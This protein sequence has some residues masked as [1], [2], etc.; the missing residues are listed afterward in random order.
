MICTAEAMATSRSAEVPPVNTVIR[1]VASICCEA[2][3]GPGTRNAGDRGQT[4]GRE[5]GKESDAQR[6]HGTESRI[7][8]PA[9]RLLPTV[10]PPSPALRMPGPTVASTSPPDQLLQHVV[11]AHDAHQLAIPPHQ[12]GGALSREHGSDPIHRGPGVDFGK[13]RFHDLA[14]RTLQ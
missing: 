5:S 1:M 13:G 10:W 8:I 7:R 3:V 11:P 14:H 2:T 9:C 12:R 6:S 4:V